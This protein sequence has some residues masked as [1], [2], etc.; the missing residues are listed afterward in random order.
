[1]TA[2]LQKPDIV[3]ILKKEGI[4]LQHRGRY[5]WATCPFHAE[6]TPSFSIDLK[7]QRFRCFGCA[8]SGDVIDFIMKFK[9]FAFRDA[10]NYLNISGD[11][12][13]KP[14][15]QE[16]RRRELVNKF[17]EWCCNYTKYICEMLRLCNRI[18]ALVNTPN[19]L[20][21]SGLGEMFLAMDVYQYHLSILS[22][23]DDEMRFQLYQEVR[24]E[25][26]I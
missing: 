4:A 3:S 7:R 20:K 8:F 21:F 9:G 14:N 17:R 13:I 10:L 19:D 22:G 16:T 1:M 15:P 2:I 18:Y 6:K 24:Y 25:K 26:R 5:L 23:K 12:P 11:R